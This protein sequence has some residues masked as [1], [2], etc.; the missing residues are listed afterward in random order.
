MVKVRVFKRQNRYYVELPD[1]FRVNG[2]MELFELRDGYYFLCN[3]LSSQL[4][5]AG[6]P[7]HIPQGTQGQVLPTEEEKAVLRKLLSIKFGQRTVEAVENILTQKEKTVF[8]QVIR[9][10]FARLFK[11]KKYKNGV[12]NIE[13]SIYPLLKE[14]TAPQI[15]EK[16]ECYAPATLYSELNSRG[17]LVLKDKNEAY[18][19]SEKLKKEMKAGAVKGVKGFDNKF[20]VVTEEYYTRGAESILNALKEDMDT[21]SVA[22]KTRLEPDGCRALLALMAENGEVIERKKGIFT[23][24]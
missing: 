18:E 20:Y 1:N 15:Q 4:N 12:Y 10:N 22:A 2:E 14:Q 11:G 8:E 17:Y 13:D 5:P 3:S 9:K 6:Q 16:K 7:I 23:P 24:V 21:A 19:L